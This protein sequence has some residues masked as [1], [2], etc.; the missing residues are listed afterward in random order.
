VRLADEVALRDEELFLCIDVDAGGSEALVRQA[1]AVERAWLPREQ[2]VQQTSVEFDEAAGRVVAV[3][4]TTFDGLVLEESRDAGPR[5]EETSRLLA[6]AASSRLDRAFPADDEAVA[7]FRV[8]AQCLAEWMP[9]LKL[10]ALDDDVLRQL[11]PQLAAGRRSLA[12]LRAAPW[13]EAI[14]GLF[15]WQQLQAIDREAPQ[16]I[17]VPSGSRIAVQYEP[18]RPPILAVRIQEV[19]GL[20]ETPRIAGGRVGVLMH[21]LAPNM[22][23]AQVTSDLA[24]FWANTYAQVRKDLRARYPKHAWPENPYQATAEKRPRRKS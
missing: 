16:R 20:L 12:E 9:E 5:S 8:R 3:R 24:S 17:E 2:V 15:S 7:E 18:G 4:R 19:F 21:L 1:S 22:R 10:P 14:K 11:L 13:L 23:P 6:A